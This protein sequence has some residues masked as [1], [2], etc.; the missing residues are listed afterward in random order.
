M[1]IGGGKMGQALAH[2]ILSANALKPESLG[3]VEVF[4][5]LRAELGKE[6]P[7][8]QI[9]ARP[10]PASS[11]LIAV[12]P[13]SVEKLAGTLGEDHKHRVLSIAAGVSTAALEVWLGG[14]PSVIRAMPNTPAML[15][16]GMTALCGGRY[17]SADDIQWA[18]SLMSAVGKVVVV[19]EVQID[20]ITAVSGSGPAYVFLVAEAMIEAAVSEGLGWDLA[21]ELVT[22]TIYGAGAMLSDGSQSPTILR[23]NVTSPGGTTAAGVGALEGAAVRAAFARAIA[24]ARERS[25]EITAELFKH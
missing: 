22:Q 20:A 11:T 8:C 17:A 24:K 19:K 9:L 5:P 1:I 13:D 7:D 12:K 25:A 16:H 6:F 3:I 4:E 10:Q 15:G 2:G 18:K 14:R 21:R 23:Q